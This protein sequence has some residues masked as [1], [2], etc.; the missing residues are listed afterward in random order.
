[1]AALD[2]EVGRP[3]DDPVMAV[4]RATATA[5]VGAY[6]AVLG[7]EGV[8]EQFHQTFMAYLRSVID[9]ARAG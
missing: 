5:A 1:M 4:C 3:A 6:L 8:S 7:Q 2:A 9:A